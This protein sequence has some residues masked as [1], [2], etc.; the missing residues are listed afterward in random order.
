[1]FN[2]N[3]T[4]DD[5]FDDSTSLSDSSTT[6]FD[7]SESSSNSGSGFDKI[8]D[9][10]LSIDEKDSDKFSFI[11]NLVVTFYDSVSRWVNHEYDKA[12]QKAV[13]TFNDHLLKGIAKP[14]S[15]YEKYYVSEDNVAKRRI[16]SIFVKQLLDNGSDIVLVGEKL[17]TNITEQDIATY[18]GSF[19][20]INQY[21]I[22]EAF[23]HYKTLAEF[24]DLPFTD[25]SLN[26]ISSSGIPG[27][28]PYEHFTQNSFA[29]AV[30]EFADDYNVILAN[31]M[32]EAIEEFVRVEKQN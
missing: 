30:N 21:A 4:D 17:K 28:Q 8:F 13:F 12:F 19:Y 16:V 10:L 22:L 31:N 9:E 15:F 27:S 24:L 25:A 20:N 32:K 3:S 6:S 2:Y 26:Q 23:V 1:M 7:S 5:I 18:F 14:F 11:S 29:L